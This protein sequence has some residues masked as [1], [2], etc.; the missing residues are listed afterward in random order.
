MK[1]LTESQIRLAAAYSERILA[2][3]SHNTMMLS[4]L[5]ARIAILENTVKDELNTKDVRQL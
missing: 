3:S 1:P 5:N 4:M 2:I